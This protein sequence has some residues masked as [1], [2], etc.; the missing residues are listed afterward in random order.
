MFGMFRIPNQQIFPLISIMSILTLLHLPVL[1]ELAVKI[2]GSSTTVLSILFQLGSHVYLFIHSHLGIR[3][4]FRIFANK[5]F[6]SV[7]TVSHQSLESYENYITC[8]HDFLLCFFYTTYNYSVLLSL[9][10]KCYAYL[11]R[12]PFRISQF[13]YSHFQEVWTFNFYF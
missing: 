11:L 13:L 2:N 6:L 3:S 4:S 10:F 12:R 7:L 8:C 1:S 9:K 5:F